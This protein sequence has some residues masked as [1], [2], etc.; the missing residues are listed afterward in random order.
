MIDICILEP[1]YQIQ[2]GVDL[3]YIL[4]GTNIRHPPLPRGV[5]WT[6]FITYYREQYMFFS[7]S[8]D[9]ITDKVTGQL[10]NTYGIHD[11]CF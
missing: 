3:V 11:K 10:D 8:K 4:L 6:Q 1:S 2:T 7:V 5:S 9:L